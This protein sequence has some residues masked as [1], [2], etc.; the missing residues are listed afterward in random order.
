ML[1]ATVNE[2]EKKKK[3]CNR[4]LNSQR[5]FLIEHLQ[6]FK[7]W[8]T[9]LIKLDQTFKGQFELSKSPVSVLAFQPLPPL[10]NVWP[11]FMV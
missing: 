5:A 8:K 4:I 7:N 6:T 11:Y 2:K 10:A 9:T 3:K 1:K